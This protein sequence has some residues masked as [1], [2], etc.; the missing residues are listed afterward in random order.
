M[1]ALPREAV[2]KTTVGRLPSEIGIRWDI[3]LAWRRQFERG[4]GTG[5][6]GAKTGK[7]RS[8]SNS[9]IYVSVC[10][11]VTETFCDRSKVTCSV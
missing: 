3:G 10:S 9:V 11:T 1:T 6:S 7:G 4:A 5:P 8:V 2:M